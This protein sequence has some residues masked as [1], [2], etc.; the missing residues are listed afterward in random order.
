MNNVD[1]YKRDPLN[2]M[3]VPH[4]NYKR[5]QIFSLLLKNY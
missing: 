3:Q 4:T 1:N 5:F 2:V